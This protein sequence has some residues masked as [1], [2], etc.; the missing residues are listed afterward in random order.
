MQNTWMAM[1]HKLFWF[2]PSNLCQQVDFKINTHIQKGH[3]SRKYQ[4]STASH[5]WHLD[6]IPLGNSWCFLKCYFFKP[7]HSED[8]S[9]LFRNR[10][11]DNTQR[12]RCLQTSKSPCPFLISFVVTS[13]DMP[14]SPVTKFIWERLEL[15]SSIEPQRTWLVI[16][17][18]Y[19]I[20]A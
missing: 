1:F 13:R 17:S 14:F 2:L 16:L 19:H 15:S 20:F 11:G 5:T 6:I 8:S 10:L 3:A 12:H 18:E 7:W 9:H 4:F